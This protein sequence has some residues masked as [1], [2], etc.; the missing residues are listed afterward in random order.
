MVRVKKWSEAT[1]TTSGASI[2]TEASVE[3]RICFPNFGWLLL[4]FGRLLLKFGW[5]LPN[6]RRLLLNF[7]R[8]LSDISLN[9]SKHSNWY[10]Y[11]PM[12]SSEVK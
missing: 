12:A 1:E 6:F 5:L 7:G 4:N 11:I 9:S 8:L 10:I 3:L 2:S